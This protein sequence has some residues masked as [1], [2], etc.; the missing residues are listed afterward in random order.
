MQT[1]P[2]PCRQ[3]LAKDR[4]PRTR[5]LIKTSNQPSKIITAGGDKASRILGI[6][7]YFWRNSD[8]SFWYFTSNCCISYRSGLEPVFAAFSFGLIGMLTIRALRS[9]A[10]SQIVSGILLPLAV[11]A[12]RARCHRFSLLTGPQARFFWQLSLFVW[13][14]GWSSRPHNHH[15]NG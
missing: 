6:F 3:P 4:A 12:L 1:G 11:T 10:F 5:F 15:S 14:F 9:L 13:A 8:R 7:Y 2:H